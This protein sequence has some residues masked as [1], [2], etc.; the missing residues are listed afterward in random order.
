MGTFETPPVSTAL[1]SI[2]FCHA[3]GVVVTQDGS[4]VGCGAATVVVVLAAG[5]SEPDPSEHAAAANVRTAIATATR[6]PVAIDVTPPPTH[7]P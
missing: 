5:C 7:R 2:A 6:P 1:S 3:A 4:V